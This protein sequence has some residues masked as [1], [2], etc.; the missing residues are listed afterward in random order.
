[1]WEQETEGT[2]MRI[3][4]VPPNFCFYHCTSSFMKQFGVFNF[5]CIKTFPFFV[6]DIPSGTDSLHMF[7]LICG[8]RRV[9]DP[10]YLVDVFSGRYLS[11]LVFSLNS[12]VFLLMFT[13]LALAVLL[14]AENFITYLHFK[15][16]NAEVTID[17]FNT[18]LLSPIFP[19]LL[20]TAEHQSSIWWFYCWENG[21]AVTYNINGREKKSSP[22]SEWLFS[23]T[24]PWLLH[25]FVCG[26][27]NI[28]E[29]TS[30][31]YCPSLWLH[32]V[33]QA[34]IFS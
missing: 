16:R 10:L 5:I 7:L 6:T 31:F 25:W 29:V 26:L 11:F 27:T 4:Q 3:F 9:K 30:K 18:L 12:D 28:S 13:N 33:N 21:F 24:V 17:L 1:M 15:K 14:I 8:L 20:G 19:S 2:I 34:D 22:T 23:L 32:A